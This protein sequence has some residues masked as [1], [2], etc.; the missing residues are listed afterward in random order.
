MA[1]T[2]PE[3]ILFKLDIFRLLRIL[4]TFLKSYTDKFH[5]KKK[6]TGQLSVRIYFQLSLLSYVS[7]SVNTCFSLRRENISGL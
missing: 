5:Y 4:L 1:E 6:N 3:M 2:C 7:I